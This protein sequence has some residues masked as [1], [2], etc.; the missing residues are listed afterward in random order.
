MT[1]SNPSGFDSNEMIRLLHS[2]G[3]HLDQRG[4]RAT[5]VVVGGAALI[6][7]GWVARST[8]DI[9]VL[10]MAPGPTAALQ[11][12]LFPA[13]LREEIARIAR[14]E[15]L[16]EDWVNHAVAMQ[17]RAGLP[18]RTDEDIEW[19]Q[20][21]NLQLGL[22]SR[23]TM[24]ALKQFAA[25]DRGPRSVHCLD[26]LALAPADAELAEA[27]AWVRQQDLAPEWPRILTEVIEHV[28]AHRRVR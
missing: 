7:R 4:I 16:P 27:E 18:P 2:L 5:L 9:D 26:L 11:R 10:A 25:A 28:R 22:A 21:G 6:L 3:R 20:F 15:S 17:W 12:P 13:E 24:L 1:P 19:H 14:D 8:E 23:H